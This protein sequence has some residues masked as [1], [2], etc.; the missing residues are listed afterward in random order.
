MSQKFGSFIRFLAYVLL[1][2]FC[3]RCAISWN[4]L[5]N[6]FSLYDLLSFFSEAIAITTALGIAYERWIWKLVPSKST[7]KL[8]PN[9]IGSISPRNSET[10]YPA[11]LEIQQ[12]LF[13]IKITLFTSESYSISVLADIQEHGTFKRIFYSY[14]NRPLATVRDRSPS[15]TGTAIL[16]IDSPD[17]LIGDYFTDRLSCGDLYFT[18][19]P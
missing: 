15:H 10:K 11:R 1:I 16:R 9:Y 5:I 4:A 2:T 14:E 19:V 18:S 8:K 3:L 13:S 12:T 7:P 6:S 17:L